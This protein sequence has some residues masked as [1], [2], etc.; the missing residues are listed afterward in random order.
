MEDS[1]GNAEAKEKVSIADTEEK[2][3]SAQMKEKVSIAV[4]K[5]KVS[6]AA[7]KGGKAF[8]SLIHMAKHPSKEH[9]SNGSPN[10]IDGDSDDPTTKSPNSSLERKAKN[11]S[12]EPPPNSPKSSLERKEKL[13]SDEPSPNSPKS[14]LERKSDHASDEP[15]PNSPKS[16]MERKAKLVNKLKRGFKV[17]KK[18]T[19][20]DNRS[21]L[22]DG[23][24]DDPSPRARSADSIKIAYGH[25]PSTD[26]TS[27]AAMNR[28]KLIERQEKLQAMNNQSEEMLDG[29]G[30]FASMAEELAKKIENKK[31]YHI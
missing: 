25:K 22:L 8:M 28:E 16:S 15:T 2:V 23:N 19:D 20:A 11:V 17:G 3:S 30:D 29:A 4:A 21:Q 1:V 24:P 7:A 26:P 18:S 31:W 9:T 13:I 6:N 5:E 10:D 12:D 27:I 14:S